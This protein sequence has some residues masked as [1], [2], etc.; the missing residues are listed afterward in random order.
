MLPDGLYL[1]GSS[2]DYASIDAVNYSTLKHI[3]VSPK[4]YQHVLAHGTSR[5]VAK[6]RGTIT[7][8]AIFEP[9]RLPLDYVVFEGTKRGKAW[10]A[11]REENQHAEIVTVEDMELACAMRDAVRSDPAAG[12]LVE[13]GTREPSLVWTD[14]ETGLRCKGRVDLV[15]DDHTIVDLKTA[16]SVR[17]WDFGRAVVTYG[18]HV[19]AAFYSDGYEAVTHSAPTYKIIAVENTPPHDV[20]VYDVTDE[21]LGIGRDEY[22]RW[23]ATVKRCQFVGEW[24]GQANGLPMRLELPP[25]AIP[26]EDGIEGLGLEM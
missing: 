4:H 6:R 12:P 21:V 11:F 24:P 19:Q 26:D 14:G 2:V 9:H 1:R 18:Y 13:G 5:T 20:I 15:H 3:A 23:L 7:H 8:T 25:W 17:P 10:D 22:Y 16:R